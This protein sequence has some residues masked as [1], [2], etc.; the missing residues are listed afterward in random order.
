MSFRYSSQDVAEALIEVG[1]TGD[2]ELKPCVEKWFAAGTVSERLTYYGEVKVCLA[3]LTTEREG[4]RQI[5][6]LDRILHHAMPE[7]DKPR[8]RT[9][10]VMMAVHPRLGAGSDLACLGDLLKVV[11]IRAEYYVQ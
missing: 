6:A 8:K 11:A 7:I 1:D 9:T 4:K 5:N 10:A 2:R 3:S